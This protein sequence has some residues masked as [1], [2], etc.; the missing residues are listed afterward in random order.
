MSPHF[1]EIASSKHDGISQHGNSLSLLFGSF[2][3]ITGQEFTVRVCCSV[4]FKS[5][6]WADLYLPFKVRIM[7]KKCLCWELCFSTIGPR[8]SNNFKAD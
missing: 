8:V 7:R 3:Q 6:A 2:P 5:A 1:E 4:S